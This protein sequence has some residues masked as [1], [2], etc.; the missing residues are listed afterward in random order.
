ML[1]L[2]PT[3]LLLLTAK[4]E[5]YKKAYLSTNKYWRIFWKKF[6]RKGQRA[7]ENKTERVTGLGRRTIEEIAK[8]NQMTALRFQMEGGRHQTSPA[9]LRG[10]LESI[11]G[12]IGYN[13]AQVLEA[14]NS[15]QLLSIHFDLCVDATGVVKE[16]SKRT[17]FTQ[18]KQ[19]EQQSLPNSR[20]T[21]WRT[22]LVED[23][24][25]H[26][27]HFPWVEWC[28]TFGPMAMVGGFMHRC[29]LHMARTKS[30][31]QGILFSQKFKQDQFNKL[32]NRFFLNAMN[33]FRFDKFCP[34]CLFFSGGILFCFVFLGKSTQLCF[35]FVFEV[36]IS[37]LSHC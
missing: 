12:F 25:M 31:G 36:I 18:Y 5:P 15:L 3:N 23:K 27:D 22:K 10:M 24:R 4:Q 14:C 32:V 29:D 20:Q 1:H 35:D 33:R 6:R 2:P 7:E 30:A 16:P 28:V 34:R 8:W 17:K 11:S 19:G 37:K 13:W 26:G 21:C 9:S